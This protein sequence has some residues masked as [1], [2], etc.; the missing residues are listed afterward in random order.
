MTTHT[1]RTVDV[2]VA[3]G[4]LRVGIWDPT[5]ESDAGE[6]PT[7]LAVHGVTSSH[8]AWAFVLPGLP[9]VRVI[10]PDLRGRGAS[11][12]LGAGGLDAHAADLA[13]VLE[14]VEAPPV[15]VAGHSMGAFVALALAHRHPDR[16]ARLVLVDGGLPLDA[17]ADLAPDDLVAAILG[18]T[19]ER[20]AMRFADEQ[21]YFDFWRAHP[22]FRDAWTP[23][24]ERY[25]AYDLVPDGEGRL[26]PAT[27]LATTTH[28][29]VDMNTGSTLTEALVGLAHPTHLLTAPRGLR[30]EPPGLYELDR[31]GEMLARHPGI[32]HDRVP[33]V[34]HYTILMSPA[35][36]E[37]VAR[38]LTDEVGAAGGVSA[39]RG[40]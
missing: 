7:I 20:L 27:S 23:E 18:P 6:I 3:G 32:V 35:G 34:N 12:G 14:A 16:V 31:L 21:A 5:V 19:A 10:A 33:D 30:D 25:F 22:A 2:P 37:V 15:V 8:L 28:D 36:G 40:A 39:E 24:L 26:R 11:N 29:T 38:V 1:Y 17:P 4:D 9:H 13:A